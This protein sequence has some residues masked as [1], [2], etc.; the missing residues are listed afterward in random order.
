MY[1]NAVISRIKLSTEMSE[2]AKRLISSHLTTF[3]G[4]IPDANFSIGVIGNLLYL[5]TDSAE[6]LEKYIRYEKPYIA[7]LVEYDMM[8]ADESEIW[9]PEQAA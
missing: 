2:M 6:L 3:C 4:F 8:A 7:H 1:L 9:E 5:S